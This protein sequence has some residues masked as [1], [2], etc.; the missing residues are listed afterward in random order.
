MKIGQGVMV[1]GGATGAEGTFET[2]IEVDDLLA[3]M[4]SGRTGIV[5]Y[6]EHP[7]V[8]MVGPLYDSL[9]AVVCEHGDDSSHVAIVARELGIPCVVHATLDRDPLELRGQTVRLDV[10]GE[11]FLVDADPGSPG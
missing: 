8:T 5:A 2:L 10:G 3:L 7:N 4:G 9:A 6:L 1:G 11:L